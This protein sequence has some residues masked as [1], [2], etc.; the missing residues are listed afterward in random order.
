MAN[1]INCEELQKNL[2]LVYNI[3]KAREDAATD[4]A[5]KL[6][7]EAWAKQSE[8]YRNAAFLLDGFCASAGLMLE[9][10]QPA[11]GTK[12]EVKRTSD[13]WTPEESNEYQYYLHQLEEG[14]I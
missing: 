4:A 12:P 8:S 5:V 7:S 9:K 11:T 1:V 13:V 2:Q 6:Q 14:R 3:F 10:S